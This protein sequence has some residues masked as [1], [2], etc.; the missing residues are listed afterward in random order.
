MRMSRNC[1]DQLSRWAVG[2]LVGLLLSITAGCSGTTEKS[3]EG[4]VAPG[5]GMS[6]NKMDQYQAHLYGGG[7]G[8]PGV[9]APSNP[10]HK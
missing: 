8:G 2:A 6:G 4:V 9:N 10:P 7:P 5:A 3:T 1:T